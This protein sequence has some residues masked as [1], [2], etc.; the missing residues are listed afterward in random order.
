MKIGFTAGGVSGPA[1]NI[2]ECNHPIASEMNAAQCLSLCFS[3]SGKALQPA[4]LQAFLRR[5][6]L[7]FHSR[8]FVFVNIRHNPEVIPSFCPLTPAH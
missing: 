2:E 5:A 8:L 3:A 4:S 1:A 6:S 7:L